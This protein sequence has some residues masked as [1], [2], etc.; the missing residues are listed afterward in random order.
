MEFNS[1]RLLALAGLHN[2][3]GDLLTEK[4]HFEEPVSSHAPHQVNSSVE[5]LF[6]KEEDDKTEGSNINVNVSGDVNIEEVELEEAKLRKAIRS[7]ILKTIESDKQRVQERK[8]RKAIRGEIQSI[9]DTM[10][11]VSE[12]HWHNYGAPINRSE[13]GVTIGFAGVG[14]KNSKVG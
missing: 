3:E 5:S 12:Q 4:N 13:E 2:E 10:G 7:E 9:I 6:Y 8:L 11:G 1:N 14:F